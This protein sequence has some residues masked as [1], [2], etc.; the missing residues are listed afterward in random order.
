MNLSTIEMEIESYDDT[1]S[2]LV[3]TGFIF[4]NKDKKYIVSV[5]HDMPIKY[6]NIKVTF[7]SLTFYTHVIHRPIWNELVVL[8]FP[9]TV[10][11]D[12]PIYCKGYKTSINKNDKLHASY[13]SNIKY[14]ELTKIPYYGFPWEYS[15]LY[16]KILFKDVCDNYK[17]G[18]P[19]YDDKK[20][21]VGIFSKREDNIGYIIPSIYL[22]KTFERLDND[23][24]YI[25]EDKN[26]TKVNNYNVNKKRNIY[27]SSLRDYIDLVC[28]FLLGRY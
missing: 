24:I 11:Y 9:D 19:I 10:D 13:I 28:Y 8:D 6:K 20:R 22:Q 26:I 1:T 18:M 4:S 21:L 12:C 27:H 14:R 17:S 3:T 2:S 16:Y 5:H 7:D 15:S 23:N 25:I